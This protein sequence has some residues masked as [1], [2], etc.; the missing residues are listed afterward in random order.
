MD[1]ATIDRTF[2]RDGSLCERGLRYGFR[3]GF[4]VVERNYSIGEDPEP[5]TDRFPTIGEAR[6]FWL[7][8]QAGWLAEGFKPVSTETRAKMPNGQIKSVHTVGDRR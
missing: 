5:H 8:V 6:A 3:K 1:N 4:H 2:R 7:K